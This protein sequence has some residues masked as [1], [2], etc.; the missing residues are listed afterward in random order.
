MS[1]KF[2]CP[3]CGQRIGAADEDAGTLGACPS[4]GREFLVPSADPPMHTFLTPRE[5]IQAPPWQEAVR[6]KKEVI[7]V[8][9]RRGLSIFA[10]L[11]SI[12]PVLN[13][14]GFVCGIIAVV[15]SDN[16]GRQDGRLLAI[17][18]MV[19]C[20]VLLIPVNVAGYLAAGP[21]LHV[22]LPGMVEFK[23]VEDVPD[24]H[25]AGAGEAP[26]PAAPQPLPKSTIA[27]NATSKIVESKPV[28][29]N[30]PDI[31]SA[32]DILDTGTQ[33]AATPSA[34]GVSP[35]AQQK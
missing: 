10:L 30:A 6:L 19:L 14:A 1:F 8:K 33:K 35:S 17:C 24:F 32:T 34:G 13:I 18:A 29:E 5:P 9:P 20:G 23:R 2:A 31:N 3:H 4:C 11:L 26:K 27:P 22:H 12:L 15:R 16:E 7:V 21:L 25:G 28:A